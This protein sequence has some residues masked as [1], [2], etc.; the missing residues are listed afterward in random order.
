MPQS[1]C[2]FVMQ[3]VQHQMPEAL[4]AG[5]QPRLP[6]I[7]PRLAPGNAHGD[8]SDI[9]GQRYHL[10]ALPDPGGPRQAEFVCWRALLDDVRTGDFQLRSELFGPRTMVDAEGEIAGRVCPGRARTR[11]VI[12]GKVDWISLHETHFSNRIRPIGA[13]VER[14]DTCLLRPI[15]SSRAR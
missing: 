13:D 8:D 10:H 4:V 11:W 12:R 2:A 5:Q 6:L 9:G 3:R 15:S 7:R 1:G 14:A